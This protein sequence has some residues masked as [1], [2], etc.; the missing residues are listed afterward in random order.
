MPLELVHCAHNAK[1]WRTAVVSRLWFIWLNSNHQGFLAGWHAFLMLMAALYVLILS[2]QHPPNRDKH[3]QHNQ[4]SHYQE[5]SPSPKP[6]STS[7]TPLSEILRHLYCCGAFRHTEGTGIDYCSLLL[8]L[9]WPIDPA[10]CPA[11]QVK[12]WW[13]YST[14]R[15]YSDPLT[16]STFL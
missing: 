15:K 16:F 1:S 12:V 8:S 9:V 7:S 3:S 10:R 2:S 14:F 4:V 11:R 5:A 13:A 6:C